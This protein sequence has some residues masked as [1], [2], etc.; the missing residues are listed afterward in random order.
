MN[1]PHNPPGTLAFI[2]VE[3]TS[4]RPERRAWEIGI[5]VARPGSPTVE[6]FHT[7]IRADDLELEHAD[8]YA[9]RIGR[10]HD[11]HPLMTK[12]PIMGYEDPWE[13]QGTREDEAYRQVEWLTR[14]AQ[15]VGWD[16]H[17]DAQTIDFRM[18]AAGIAPSF[19]YH[20]INLPDLAAGY[21]IGRYGKEWMADMTKV[22]GPRP[23][24]MKSEIREHLGIAPQDPWSEHTAMGDARENQAMFYRIMGEPDDLEQDPA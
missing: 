23:R 20:H 21:L 3:T 1:Q 16:V 8:P 14:G 19:D 12:Q 18:R 6:Q 17:F 4:T 9:L 22:V 10:F 11:R 5:I 2:D 15:L 24:W 13:T 7:F